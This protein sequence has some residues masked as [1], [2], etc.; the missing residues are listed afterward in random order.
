[1]GLAENTPTSSRWPRATYEAICTEERTAEDAIARALFIASTRNPQSSP[2]IIGFALFC[3]ISTTGGGECDLE[4]MVVAND[5]RRQGI[6]RRLLNTGVLWCRTWCSAAQ[7]LSQDGL[8]SREGERP[9]VAL[10]LE[11]RASNRN[12]IAFY[13][14]AGLHISGR[15]TGYYAQPTE[16]AV[17]MTAS[18]RD[19]TSAC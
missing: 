16:D 17:L 13:E 1:M 2:E 18:L 15:R 10:W 6:G 19:L 8:R 14:N 3:A 9:D 4:N 5:C 12:A 11:V 7:H